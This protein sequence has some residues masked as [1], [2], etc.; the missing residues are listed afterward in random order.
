VL[1]DRLRAQEEFWVREG[2]MQRV[3]DPAPF[4]NQDFAAEAVQLLG[5]GTNPPA[6][7]V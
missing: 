1:I 5:R 6:P 2:V 4:V 3:V 7:A